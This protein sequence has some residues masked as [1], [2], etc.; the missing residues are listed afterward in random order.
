M[1]IL[2]L[3]LKEMLICCDK[4]TVLNLSV[5]SEC[6]RSTKGPNPIIRPIFLFFFKKKTASK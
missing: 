3:G 1:F 4:D 6:A 2:Q 5:L